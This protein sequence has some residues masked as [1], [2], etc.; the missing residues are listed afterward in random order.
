MIRRPSTRRRCGGQ[1]A[2]SRVVPQRSTTISDESARR[3]RARRRRRSRRRRPSRR[4]SHSAAI[5]SFVTRATPSRRSSRRCRSSGAPT[6]RCAAASSAVCVSPRLSRGLA[7]SSTNRPP[8]SRRPTWPSSPRKIGRAGGLK[9]KVMANDELVRERMG[10]V[11]GVGEGSERPPRFLRLEYAPPNARGRLAFVGKGVVF[12]SGGL[13]LKTAGG[14]ETM[15]TDM[16]GAAAVIA[17][18]SALPRSR[19]EDASRSATCRSSRTCRAGRRC[20]P[21]TCSRCATGRPSRC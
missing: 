13:S 12:D 3:S 6:R 4:A 21:A 14:M 10:G 1:R 2:R 11:L 20:G 9:V 18:M 16:S 19:R 7:I 17:A 15:K 5:N 8:R